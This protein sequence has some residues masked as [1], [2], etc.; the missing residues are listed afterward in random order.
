V[1][2][3]NQ[4]AGDGREHDLG[5][6]GLQAAE[7]VHEAR[8]RVQRALLRVE[9]CCWSGTS[10]SRSRRRA[11][12]RSRRAGRCTAV[13]LAGT[14][15]S[16]TPGSSR[17]RAPSSRPRRRPPRSAGR[18]RRAG[19]TCLVRVLA[20]GSRPA[21]P[22][23][24]PAPGCRRSSV[25]ADGGHALE[26][27]FEDLGARHFAGAQVLGRVARRELLPV[28]VQSGSP[29][30]RP[31]IHSLSTGRP[32]VVQIF[33]PGSRQGRRPWP[34]A[35]GSPPWRRRCPGTGSGTSLAELRDAAVGALVLVG[36]GQDAQ[37]FLVLELVP[38]SVMHSVR[39]SCATVWHFAESWRL[40]SHFCWQV[41]SDWQ[42]LPHSSNLETVWHTS[43][44][45]PKAASTSPGTGP[46]R[47]GTRRRLGALPAAASASRS[48]RWC[49][50]SGSRRRPPCRSPIR[51]SRAGRRWTGRAAVGLAEHPG[52]L[53]G[54]R[55]AV[56][57][58]AALGRHRE[59]V[60][61]GVLVVDA[62][63]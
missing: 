48:P 49:R 62:L 55:V 63:A 4:P 10:T 30:Q 9:T 7:Q 18:R 42:T 60:V 1:E 26:Q 24:G 47:G 56:A 6:V 45:E 3:V 23:G 58:V 8:R 32:R 21:T 20:L 46:R 27:L 35:A 38:H 37:E 53:A 34:A 39:R 43:M 19:R 61:A 2:P 28:L 41:Q 50:G 16:N 29:A 5:R 57:L 59:Q 14:T 44:Q 54:V 40:S 11:C 12:S 52:A 31:A 51:T 13:V 25:G 22:P 36:A 33:G 17:T 15:L